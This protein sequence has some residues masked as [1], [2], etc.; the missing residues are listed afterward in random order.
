MTLPQPSA[1][2][3]IVWEEPPKSRPPRSRAV[4]ALLDTRPGKW[5]RIDGPGPFT[6]MPWWAAIAQSDD[7]ET[8]IVH[9]D[10]KVLGSRSIY[11]RRR[12]A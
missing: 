7:Y 11:A 3:E 10:S 8:K 6:M 5:A 12:V 9:H 1:G 4:M 2:P